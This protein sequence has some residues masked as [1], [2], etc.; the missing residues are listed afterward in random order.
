MIFFTGFC[1]NDNKY[2]PANVYIKAPSV[3]NEKLPL[4]CSLYVFAP[5]GYQISLFTNVTDNIGIF[6]VTVYDYLESK[7]MNVLA[8]W[9]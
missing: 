5:D 4:T 6:N 7:G 9:A 3:S 8:S 2:I 1:D